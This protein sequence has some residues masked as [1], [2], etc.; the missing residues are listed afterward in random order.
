MIV[1][2]NA[3]RSIIILTLSPLARGGGG[4]S[5]SHHPVRVP[6]LSETYHASRKETLLV[7]CR[8][9]CN[10]V[11][12]YYVTCLMAKP[13]A[14]S[15]IWVLRCRDRAQHYVLR[16]TAFHVGFACCSQYPKFGSPATSALQEPSFRNG[17]SCHGKGETENKSWRSDQKRCRLLVHGVAT[18]PKGKRWG[19]RSALAGTKTRPRDSTKGI[20]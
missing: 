20:Y 12:P 11:E 1:L 6:Q 19:V 8:C 5:T 15:A 16:R 3:L 10:I 14:V 17:L 18:A 7:N 13:S 2:L 9:Q 4:G